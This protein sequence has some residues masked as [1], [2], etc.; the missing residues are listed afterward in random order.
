MKKL[1]CAAMIAVSLTLPEVDAMIDVSLTMP[2]MAYE[3]NDDL[4]TRVLDKIA[5]KNLL[6]EANELLKANSDEKITGPFKTFAADVK[7]D[8]SV[9]LAYIF[10]TLAPTMLRPAPASA[11]RKI[12]ELLDE[13]ECGAT[14]DLNVVK[15]SL[16]GADHQK[17]SLLAQRQEIMRDPI[18]CCKIMNSAGCS[19]ED[20]Q[21]HTIAKN[22]QGMIADLSTDAHY[23]QAT[24]LTTPDRPVLE[25]LTSA[26]TLHR[27]AEA[28]A[29][30]E[31]YTG[32]VISELKKDLYLE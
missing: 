30:I 17:T 7:I 11:V 4:N 13:M 26:D 3:L 14:P 28:L 31:E 15:R 18:L 1:I 20:F 5:D 12:R 6:K 27:I 8:P 16:L 23:I 29:K 24:L 22:I 10:E 21:H 25:K 2:E 9:A 32:R 19:P